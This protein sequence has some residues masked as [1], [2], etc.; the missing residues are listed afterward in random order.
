MDYLCDAD[1][2]LKVKVKEFEIRKIAYITV[3]DS[4]KEDVV[5][6]ALKYLIQWAKK[7]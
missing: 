7:N 2:E 4:F 1:K 5:V 3:Y 6:D